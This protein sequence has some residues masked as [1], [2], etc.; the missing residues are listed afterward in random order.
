MSPACSRG[1][2]KSSSFAAGKEVGCVHSTEDLDHLRN[3]PGPAGLVT[4]AKTRS[5]VAVKVLIEQ[6]VIVPMRIGLE[7]L[8][9]SIHGTATRISQK[10]P[11]QPIGD[12]L[13][14]LEQVLLVT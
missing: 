8:R 12:L 4:G 11:S 1:L 7:L 2:P 6:N 3:Q 5:I 9:P 14:Y 13:G 10:D